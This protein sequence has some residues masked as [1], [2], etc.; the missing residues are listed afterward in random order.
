MIEIRSGARVEIGACNIAKIF[1]EIPLL[2]IKTGP[3]KVLSN[4]S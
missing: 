3:K 1:I 4:L 2:L